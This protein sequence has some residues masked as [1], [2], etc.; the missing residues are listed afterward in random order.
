VVHGTKILAR[1]IVVHGSSYTT[2]FA[3]TKTGGFAIMRYRLR[4]WW[5]IPTL[6]PI[7]F[8]ILF[9]RDVADIDFERPFE[10]FSLLEIFGSCKVV[11]P[12]VLPVIM[13]MLQHGMKD[14]HRHQDDPDSPL[15]D[16]GNGKAPESSLGVPPSSSRRR[17]MSLTKE[18]ESRRKW[19]MR[20]Y[21]GNIQLTLPRGSST[22][23]RARWR[24]GNRTTHCHSIPRRS[25]LQI[26]RV[27][28]LCGIF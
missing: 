24:T 26:F 28:G 12:N 23:K 7:C 22:K 15:S 11:Y 3:A 5:D 2:K 8:S 19:L 21:L 18:L 4:R 10:L 13:S 20:Y 27:Q 9:A 16:K 17:S 14:V 1:L 6:W 25:T